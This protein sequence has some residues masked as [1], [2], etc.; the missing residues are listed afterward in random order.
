MGF[1]GVGFGS[2]GFGMTRVR[3]GFF[4]RRRFFRGVFFSF[5]FFF[6]ALVTL[7]SLFGFP[8]CMVEG[9][10]LARCRRF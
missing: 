4:R 5:L 7:A 2:L 8:D 9:F 3:E 10:G 6:T 1:L